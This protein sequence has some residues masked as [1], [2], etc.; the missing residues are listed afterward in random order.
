VERVEKQSMR[1]RAAAV[2]ACLL[3]LETVLGL[4]MRGVHDALCNLH[5]VPSVD[6]ER[7]MGQWYEVGRMESR[8]QSGQVGNSGNFSTCE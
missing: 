4:Q 1:G 7:F 8:Y 5:P 3:L 2:A 6:L